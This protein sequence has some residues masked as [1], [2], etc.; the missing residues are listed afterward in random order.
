VETKGGH[1]CKREWETVD[2]QIKEAFT[3]RKKREEWRKLCHR[4]TYHDINE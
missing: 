4:T 3:G 1:K 2:T